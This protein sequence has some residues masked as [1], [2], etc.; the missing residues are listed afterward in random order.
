MT[1]QIVPATPENV[2][3]VVERLAAGEL[4]ALPTE[5][6]YGLAADAENRTA[7]AA[8]FA[9]K[10]RPADHPLI[11]HLADA[12]QVSRYAANWSRAAESLA[13]H[14]WPGPLTLVVPAQ[15]RVL[16]EVTGGQPTVA[17]RVPDHPFTREVI[18]RLGRGVVAP[19][20]N[21][22]GRVSPT[23][24]A[25]VTA[26]FP[27][28]DLWIAD[29]GATPVGVESTIVDLSREA[30][31]VVV[32]RPGAVGEEAIAQVLRDAGLDLPVFSA[33]GRD[34]KEATLPPPRVP[35]ALPSHYAPQ[36]PLRLW[37]R[38][39]YTEYGRTAAHTAPI[40]HAVWFPADWAKLPGEVLRLT[41]PESPVEL[42]QQLYAA[43]R[44]LDASGAEELWVALPEGNDP[45]MTAVRDRLQRAAHR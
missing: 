8:V 37:R 15:P 35:G 13:R 11:V 22:F 21:R 2:A 36:T 1:P 39:A 19:S 10:G 34:R 6:V 23:T 25:H 5:T 16:P 28:L 7:V 18:T 29:A 31:G 14:F 12:Q 44:A 33:G 32:L 41:Q 27:A 26:E 30:V 24:A 43:L 40:P 17:L 4:V 45:L 9:A 38:E 42:A 3:R 20:A